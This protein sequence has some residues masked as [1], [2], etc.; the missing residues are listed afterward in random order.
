MDSPREERPKEDVLEKTC[1]SPPSCKTKVVSNGLDSSQCK[2]DSEEVKSDSGK[3][4]HGVE[5]EKVERSGSPPRTDSEAKC[6]DQEHKSNEGDQE[7]EE[8]DAK[9]KQGI[10]INIIGAR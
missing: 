3:Q 10:L 2:S 6:N 7:E 9:N 8:E 5:G 1:L 4:T